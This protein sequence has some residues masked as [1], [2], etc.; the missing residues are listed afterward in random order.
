[1]QAVYPLLPTN[2]LPTDAANARS[3]L[4]APSTWGECRSSFARYFKTGEAFIFNL[5]SIEDPAV[6]QKILAHLDDN[7]T[8]ATLAL[9]PDCRVSPTV[10]LFVSRNKPNQSPDLLFPTW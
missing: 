3:I 9:L 5:T 10:G 7:A 6:N 1:L 4:I 2:F 8:S